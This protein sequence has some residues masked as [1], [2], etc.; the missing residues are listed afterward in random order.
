MLAFSYFNVTYWLPEI[1]SSGCKWWRQ[2]KCWPGCWIWCSWPL[3]TDC[4][5]RKE[6]TRFRE[7]RQ[8]EHRPAGLTWEPKAPFPNSLLV[9]GLSYLLPGPYIVQVMSGLLIIY[10]WNLIIRAFWK[11][12]ICLQ[13]GGWVLHAPAWLG[14]GLDCEAGEERMGGGKNPSERSEKNIDFK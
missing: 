3:S 4:F 7:Y 8:S 2:I 5:L 1:V 14:L 12:H 9:T 10:N 11:N 6:G 13:E